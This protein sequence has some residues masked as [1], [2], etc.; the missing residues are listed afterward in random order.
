LR[1]SPFTLT[2]VTARAIARAGE[3]ADDPVGR[4]RKDD[5]GRGWRPGITRTGPLADSSTLVFER[6]HRPEVLA[7][8]KDREAKEATPVQA[9]A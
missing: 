2:F 1:T 4:A 8:L 9:R 3:Y 7:V 5:I 6:P